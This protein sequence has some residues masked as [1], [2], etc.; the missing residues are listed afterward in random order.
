MT[1]FEEQLD[2]LALSDHGPMAATQQS[3]DEPEDI[4]IDAL[5]M[6]PMAGETKDSLLASLAS[7]SDS[8]AIEPIAENPFDTVPL[9]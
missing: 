3:R 8:F 9:R 7:L 2:N 1:V 4:D 6:S 5:V